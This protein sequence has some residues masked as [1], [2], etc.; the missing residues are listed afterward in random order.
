MLESVGEDSGKEEKWSV[1]ET[2]GKPLMS[3]WES[4]LKLYFLQLKHKVS[5]C[6]FLFF[7]CKLIFQALYIDK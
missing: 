4:L 1:K 3:Y 2:S 5:D 6:G 7:L